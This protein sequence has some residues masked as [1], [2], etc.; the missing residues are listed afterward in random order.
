L[1]CVNRLE[2]LPP[3]VG[4]DEASDVVRP[5]HAQLV[6]ASLTRLVRLPTQGDAPSYFWVLVFAFGHADEG[7][8][9]ER[10]CKQFSERFLAGRMRNGFCP[11]APPDLLPARWAAWQRWSPLPPAGFCGRFPGGG[12]LGELGGGEAGFHG[13]N[14]ATVVPCPPPVRPYRCVTTTR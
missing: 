3:Q 7:S 6:C 10:R 13:A 14:S 2:N 4:F 8:R 9:S 12:A 1:E 11:C 5:R